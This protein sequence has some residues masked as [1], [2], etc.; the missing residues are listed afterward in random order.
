M[1][2]FS[3]LLDDLLLNSSKKKK[4]K[5]LKDYFNSLETNEKELALSI[6]SQNFS[7]KLI[8]ANDIKIMIKR[9]ISE[10]LFS[11]SYAKR[12]LAIQVDMYNKKYNT[13]YNYLI[14]C[15]LYGE[16]DKFDQ[17]KIVEFQ[18]LGNLGE[19]QWNEEGA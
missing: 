15:N 11:Y 16:Y 8:K 4:I 6:L 18:G 12:C 3:K 13:N 10:D 19:I 14:P 7:T 5:I 17:I 2:K 9:K 1:I